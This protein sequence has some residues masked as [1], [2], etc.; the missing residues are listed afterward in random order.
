MFAGLLMLQRPKYTLKLKS[1]YNNAVIKICME[2]P[3][4]EFLKKVFQVFSS[5]FSKHFQ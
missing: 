4:V 1:I 5:E 2:I 3:V